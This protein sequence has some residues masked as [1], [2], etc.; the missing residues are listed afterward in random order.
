MKEFYRKY[1]PKTLK[2]IVGQ[3]G[4]IASLTSLIEN[5]SIPHFLLLSGPSGCGK[6]TVAR[7]LKDILKCD[8]AD[9]VERNTADFKGVDT[10]REVRRHLNL[11]PIAGP[12]RIHLID[13]AHKLTPDAQE[14]FLKM[15]EDTPDHAYFIFATTD[16]EKLKKAIHTRATEIVFVE[17]P[18]SGLMKVIIR[19][20]NKENIQ[21]KED[22]VEAI[23]EAAEGSPRKALVILQQV[24]KLSSLTEQ[25]DA[26]KATTFNKDAAIE[27]ARE[28]MSPKPV[29]NKVCKIL[30][31]IQDQDPEGIR[32]LILGYANSMLIGKRGSPAKGRMAANCYKILEIFGDNFYSSKT[33]GLTAACYE[34]VFC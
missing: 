4:A 2:G 11:L 24:C 13:E 18:V 8:D 29:W 33:Y 19:V 7:I 27:L 15:L 1:R 31:D 5:N 28:L 16:P 17:V 26:I 25:L 22:V 32:Y 12:C 6:T 20:C 30:R 3:S 9:F 14:A 23:A 21:L 10:V 34:A